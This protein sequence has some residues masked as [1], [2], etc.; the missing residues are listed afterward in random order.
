MLSTTG[1]LANGLATRS[2]YAVWLTRVELE[3]SQNLGQRLAVVL[4]REDED[5]HSK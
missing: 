5:A 1:Q 3:A 4:R 2:T